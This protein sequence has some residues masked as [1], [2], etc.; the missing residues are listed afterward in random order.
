MFLVSVHPFLSLHDLEVLIINP[1]RPAK[2]RSLT[3][4]GLG[5]T[6]GENVENVKVEFVDLLCAVLKIVLRIFEGLKER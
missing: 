1:I 5:I 2:N 3:F 4:L 6:L